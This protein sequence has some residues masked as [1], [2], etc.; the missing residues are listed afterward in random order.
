MSTGISIFFEEFICLLEKLSTMNCPFI[1][2]GDLNIHFE[3]HTD[4]SRRLK[5]I[6]SS[7]N[8]C[9]HVTHPT[10][11]FGHTIDMVISS[12][13]DLP[14]TNVEVYDVSLSDHFLISFQV[15][16]TVPPVR[17]KEITFR[18]LKSINHDLF[19]HD[20]SHCLS[21]LDMAGSFNDTICNY[22]NTLLAVIDNHAPRI[23][24]IIKDV[25]KAPWFN[26]DY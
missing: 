5:S 11:K 23:T 26:Q 17:T 7:F 24:K 13:S 12:E 25:S 3:K 4:S 10:N 15:S 20:L 9:Q 19:A 14:V 8:L 22:N 1:L 6:L 18:N 16:C 2:A 21:D